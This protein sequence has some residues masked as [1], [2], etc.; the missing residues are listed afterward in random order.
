MVEKDGLNAEFLSFDQS[1]RKSLVRL[2]KICSQSVREQ[3]GLLGPKGNGLLDS[4]VQ[5]GQIP[6]RAV[7]GGVK[8][9]FLRLMLFML[10][11]H[12]HLEGNNPKKELIDR[13]LLEN[14]YSPEVALNPTLASYYHFIGEQEA[15]RSFNLVAAVAKQIQKSS[16]PRVRA[17]SCLNG[18][19][20]TVGAELDQLALDYFSDGFA[21]F[22]LRSYEAAA[23]Y[24]QQK[25]ERDLILSGI[26]PLDDGRFLRAVFILPNPVIES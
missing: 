12:Y 6:R 18:D 8:T 17:G 19:R 24:L 14:P 15:V 10:V 26:F 1:D 23:E 16:L 7:E 13:A 9:D 11:A 2:V 20:P 21:N 4:F 3:Y 25:Q 5:S 22:R